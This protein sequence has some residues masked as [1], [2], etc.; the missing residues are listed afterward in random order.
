MRIVG[1][2]RGL[3]IIAGAG[4]AVLT[5]AY[6]D[7]APIWQPLPARIPGRDIWVYGSGLVL[8]AGSAGLCFSRT[9]RAGAL[10]VGAYL[11]AWVVVRA[12]PVVS[13]PLSVG[14]WY[15]LC[16]ALAPLLGAFILYAMLRRQSPGPAPARI[17]SGRAVGA[18]QACF[19]VSCAVFGVAHFAYADLTASM[20]PVWLPG[21]L[22]FAYLTGLAHLAAG[23]GILIKILPRLAAT[24]EAIMM[25]SF[26]LLVWVPSLFAQPPPRWATPPQNQWSE[27]FLTVLL[28][29]SAW[30]VASSLRAQPW[31][32]RQPR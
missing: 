17:A 7:F 1:P 28:A 20:V 2:G 5:F 24:L 32:G 22:G 3:F 15:G 16:E 30:V 23:I 18:A 8:L 10:A 27:L 12:A 14:S 13:E 11:L 9:A 19:G 31:V 21:H 29:G 6:R 4:L 25:S 26:G